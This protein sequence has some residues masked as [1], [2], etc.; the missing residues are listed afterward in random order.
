MHLP[1]SLTRRLMRVFRTIVEISMLA[2]F[3]TR[4]VRSLGSFVAFQ[5]IGGAHL[6]SVRQP[7]EQLT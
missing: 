2:V 3:H 7:L 6:W 4:H 5:L 1:L